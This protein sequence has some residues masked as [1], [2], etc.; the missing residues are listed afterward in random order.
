MLQ[1]KVYQ[2]QI[3]NADHSE[4]AS[5]A[6]VVATRRKLLTHMHVAV[7]LAKGATD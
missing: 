1:V 3:T 4:A 6:G 7:P 5:A 2:T